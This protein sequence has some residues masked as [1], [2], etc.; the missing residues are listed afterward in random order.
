MQFNF[1]PEIAHEDFLRNSQQ[2]LAFSPERD[3]AQWRAEVDAKLRQLLG[4][5]HFTKVDPDIRI[6]YEKEC[7]DFFE[8]RFV[9]A[10][11]YKVDVPVHL[12]VPKTGKGPYPVMICLQ[13]HS[14]GM[15]ISLARPKYDGDEKSINS[16]DRDFA[17]QAV[18]HGYAALVMEQR[19]FGERK[20][21]RPK[22]VHPFHP[23]CVHPSMLELLLGRCM[24]AARCWDVSRSID[25]LDRFANV[26]VDR[27]ACMGNSG[28]GT[29]TFFSTCLDER[30]K[31]AMPS[32]YFCTLK[33]SIGRIDHCVDNYVPGM[34]QWFDLPDLTCLITPRPLVIVAGAKDDIF[35]ISGVKTAFGK[36]CEIYRSAGAEGKCKLFV[37]PEGH[38]FYADAWNEFLALR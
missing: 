38:R 16:G 2:K 4:M 35:P 7:A 12:L 28:G 20:D 22:S 19:A 31:M 32:C 14:T 24:T 34:L 33:E 21:S 25:L 36:A 23:G 9:F 5:E 30:I 18:R 3:F 37:G 13:G 1:A 27:I 29:I 6:E 17:I 8:T 11:E 15:H 10:A 26:D